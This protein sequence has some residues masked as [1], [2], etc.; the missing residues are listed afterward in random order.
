MTP[1]VYGRYPKNIDIHTGKY[2]V[3]DWANFLHHYSI[4][5]FK[6]NM[7]DDTFIIWNKFIMGTL[8][9]TKTEITSLDIDDAE[10]AF[11]TFMNCYY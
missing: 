4:P 8:L 5:L 2:K 3:E 10:T 1:S 7:L 11:A 9:A 6:D